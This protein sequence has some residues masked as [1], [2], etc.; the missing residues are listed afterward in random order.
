[1][2]DDPGI[3]SRAPPRSCGFVGGHGGKPA[4]ISEKPRSKIMQQMQ[5]GVEK[6]KPKV[7]FEVGRDGAVIWSVHRLPTAT[8]KKSTTRRAVSACR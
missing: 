4:P 5:E 8:S 3:W 7:L 2:T 6:P 1:M